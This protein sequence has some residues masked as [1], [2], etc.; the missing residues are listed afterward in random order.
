[1]KKLEFDRENPIKE[2]TVSWNGILKAKPCKNI[3][4][5]YYEEGKQYFA[6]LTCEGNDIPPIALCLKT[7]YNRLIP[8]ICWS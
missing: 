8:H 3:S 2:R 7:K 4:C 1:M 6:M 5:T